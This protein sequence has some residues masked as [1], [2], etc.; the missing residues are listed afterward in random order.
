MKIDAEFKRSLILSKSQ[1][2]LEMCEELGLEVKRHRVYERTKN[3]VFLLN[4]GHYIV[5]RISSRGR[6]SDNIVI[7]SYKQPVVEKMDIGRLRKCHILSSDNRITSI[8]KEVLTNLIDHRRDTIRNT[9]ERIREYAESYAT[10]NQFNITTLEGVCAFATGELFKALKSFN[11]N[12]TIHVSIDTPKKPENFLCYHTFLKVE[13][14]VID[15]TA[16]QFKRPKILIEKLTSL[17]KKRWFWKT[18][19]KFTDVKSLV[20]WQKKHK[21]PE[22]QLAKV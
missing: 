14:Y 16:T 12:S 11:I 19:L 8:F 3:S 10:I 15:V 7:Y 17:E 9:A 21:I 18:H 13:D 1:Q 20:E 5:L 6:D 22:D 4:S 2:I